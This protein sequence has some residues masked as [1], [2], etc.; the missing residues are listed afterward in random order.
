MFGVKAYQ[1]V[2]MQTSSPWQLINQ[3]YT[4]AIQAIDEG[5]IEKAH[6]IVEEGLFANL[7]PSNPLSKGY[8]ESYEVVMAHLRPGGKLETA[9][10]VLVTLQEAWF[11]IQQKQAA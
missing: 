8:A 7:T 1:Q 5:K 6:R 9:R 3:L 10:S 11:G 2:A 4:G